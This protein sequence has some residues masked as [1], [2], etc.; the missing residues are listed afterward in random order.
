[1]VVISP[2]AENDLRSIKED[3]AT[4]KP[5]AAIKRLDG[6]LKIFDLIESHPEVGENRTELIVKPR[7]L[8]GCFAL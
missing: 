5:S 1:M 2:S 3:V 6:I 7:Q 4:D 8:D